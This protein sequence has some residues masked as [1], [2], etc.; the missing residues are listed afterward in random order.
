MNTFHI[1]LERHF[2][3]RLAARER[4]LCA[5]LSTADAPSE[6]PAR[7]GEVGDFKDDAVRDAFAAAEAAKAERAAIELEQVLVARAR[8]HDHRFGRCSE[9]DDP[10][11]LDR[12]L[13]LPATNCCTACQA[14]RERAGRRLAH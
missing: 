4:E 5:V 7:A 3:E 14:I 6:A 12:L 9:C 11:P 2:D 10:I 1:S 8:L 13:V